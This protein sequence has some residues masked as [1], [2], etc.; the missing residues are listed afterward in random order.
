MLAAFGSLLIILK[1]YHIYFKSLPRSSY[2]DF[3]SIIMD[4]N[5]NSER[6]TQSEGEDSDK[7]RF[8]EMA[9]G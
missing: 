1:G 3:D 5:N 2:S 4:N 8:S 7:D 6:S 9:N